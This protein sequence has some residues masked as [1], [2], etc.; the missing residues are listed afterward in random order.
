[1]KKLTLLLLC[2]SFGFTYPQF[3]EHFLTQQQIDDKIEEAKAVS[4]EHPKKAIRHLEDVYTEAKKTGYK[5]AML[6]SLVFRMMVH[7]DIGNS[8]KIINFSDEAEKLAIELND[9]ELLCHIYRLKGQA[10]DQ[11][12]FF[13]K[14][15]KEL[16]KSLAISEKISDSNPKYYN[17][18]LIYQWTH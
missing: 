12:A 7:F 10:Y 14:S 11:L 13:D 15:R 1:M 16:Q 9:I 17:Q 4:I 2:M 8:K 3:N 5:K 6:E 18:A